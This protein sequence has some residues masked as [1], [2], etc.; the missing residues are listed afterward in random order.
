MANKERHQ[1]EQFVC[2]F[3]H[4]ILKKASLTRPKLLSMCLFSVQII[5]VEGAF[6]YRC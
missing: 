4:T 5:V 6:L 2:T 1:L 3:C